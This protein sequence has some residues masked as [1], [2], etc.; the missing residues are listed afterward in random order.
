MSINNKHKVSEKELDNLLGQAFLNLDYTNPKNQ[1]LMETISNQYLHS[2]S[3][4]FS[5]KKFILNKLIIGITCL[6]IVVGLGIYF[7][8]KTNTSLINKTK[9]ITP[10]IPQSTVSIINE[11]TKKQ[12]PVTEKQ[13]ASLPIT[14]KENNSSQ[15]INNYIGSIYLTNNNSFIET[16][17]EPT[18]NKINSIVSN[19]DTGYVYPVLTEKE[20]KDNHKQKRKMVEALAKLSKDI[21]LPI[22]MGTFDYN[23]QQVS[24]NG[25]YMETTEVSNLEYLTFVFDLLIQ[26]RKEDFLKA[27]PDQSQWTKAFINTSYD[28]TNLKNTY[29][30]GKAYRDY[31]IVNI[32]R[33][34]AEMYCKWLT[35]A[36]NEYLAS[37][38]KPLI[39]DLRLPTNHE[40][41]YAARSGTVTDNFPWKT[42]VVQNK[43]GCFLANF[44]IKNF[45][46]VKRDPKAKCKYDYPDAITTA[47]TI[48]GPMQTTVMIAA[49]NPN[50]FGLY[51][52]CGNVAE[53]VYEEN[54]I[55]KAKTH[56]TRGGSWYSDVDYLK[57][58]S[59]NEFKNVTKPS[60][61]IGFR[62]VM[63][64][65]KK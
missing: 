58:T 24:L 26:N 19:E 64:M 49:Y 46:E 43:L 63:T 25:F 4:L 59:E 57:L 39:N 2:T 54:L 5:I 7:Y 8:P 56:G 31:P 36:T 21:Y 65:L 55:T 60:P 51:C 34:G 53:M 38:N 33:E 44:C 16:D 37:K 41:T 18:F 61:M 20:I 42:D 50:D 40:W 32:S 13:I 45:G 23:G 17:P 35:N 6:T 14:K 9:I 22:P 47:G 52:M 1:E 48:L 15:T 27:K 29:F 28:F 3:I 62:P 12:N 11:Q 30:S 10:E